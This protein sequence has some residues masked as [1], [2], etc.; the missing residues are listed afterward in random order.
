MIAPNLHVRGTIRIVR[1]QEAEVDIQIAKIRTGEQIATE[2][3][4]IPISTDPFK[5]ASTPAI[6]RLILKLMEPLDP[7]IQK[8]KQWLGEPFDSEKINILVADFTNAG[9]EVDQRSEDITSATFN[10]LDKFMKE[11]RALSEVVEVKRL[12]SKGSD[13]VIREE[14]QAKEIGEA[15]NAD[16]VIW[17]QNLCVGDSICVFAKAFINHEARAAATADEGVLHKYQLL[18]AD[19]PMLIGAQAHVLVKFVIGWTYLKDY[20]HQQFQQALKYLQQALS[21]TI[22]V[23]G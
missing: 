5:D 4:L 9:G 18:R 15:L 16:M 20:R 14:T 21:E 3:T 12:S 11:D 2:H 23:K 1:Q 6:R 17:G 8:Q 22:L 19:L 10:K 13:R 7:K